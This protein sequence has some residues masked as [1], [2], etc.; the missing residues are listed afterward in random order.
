MTQ[1]TLRAGHLIDNITGEHDVLGGQDVI[2]VLT[3]NVGSG[4]DAHHRIAIEEHFFSEIFQLQIAGFG[5]DRRYLRTAV[6]GITF[7]A[8]TDDWIASIKGR[9]GYIAGFGQDVRINDR[10]FVGGDSLRGFEIGG[11]GPRDRLTGDALGGTR[12]YTA[13]AEVKFPLTTL[14]SFGFTGFIFTDLG[15]LG[16][17]E[18]TGPDVLAED[19]VRASVGVGFGLKTPLGPVRVNWA[20]AVIK[21][22]FDKTEFFTFSFGTRF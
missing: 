22:N 3:G 19:S 8:L 16:G 14:A 1:H 7:Y 21:E 11:I 12:F 6:S 13:S 20:Q 4:Y 10:F 2:F 15:S 18:E 17:S 9:V 5:G